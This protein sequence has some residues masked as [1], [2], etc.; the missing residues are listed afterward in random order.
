MKVSKLIALLHFVKNKEQ[1]IYLGSDEE[2][3]TMY[4]DLEINRLEN[5][6]LVIFGLSGSEVEEDY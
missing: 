3:N 1:E 4:K 6:G 5:G 2:L